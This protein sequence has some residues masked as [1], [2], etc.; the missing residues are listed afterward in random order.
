MERKSKEGKGRE[1]KVKGGKEKEGIG[2]GGSQAFFY[3]TAL[4]C[5]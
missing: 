4:A 2:G 1:E 3:F 5:L